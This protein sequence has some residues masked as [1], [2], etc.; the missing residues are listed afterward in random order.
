MRALAAVVIALVFGIFLATPAVAAMPAQTA[1]ASTKA[2]RKA[3]TQFQHDLVS[4]LALRSEAK[5]LLGA[6]LLAR[7]LQDLPKVIDFHHLI[8]R[9][10]KASD[11]GP[12]VTW[13]Q[14]VDCDAKTQA[15]PNADALK[16]LQQQAPDNAAVWLLALGQDQHNDNQDA[17]KADLKQAADADKYDDYIGNSLQ[18]LALAVATLPPLPDTMNPEGTLA[19]SPSGVQAML[20]F[21]IGSTQPLPGFQAAAALCAKNKDDDSMSDQCLKLGK[22][23]EWGSSALARS[24]GLHLRET[25]SKDPNEQADAKSARRDLIWQ[26]QNFTHLTAQAQTDPAVANRLLKLA[27]SGGTQMSMM[28]T[29]LRASN[30]PIE[31]PA[32]WQPHKSQ[33]PSDPV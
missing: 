25:L 26:V 14:L 10:A 2:Q 15:C 21:G 17:V 9:A 20:V 6:A 1:S 12:A 18:A 32:D 3:L 33:E 27:R 29:A 8:T 13:A 5:P 19:S 11:A 30:I 16:K 28:L 7:P 22:T 23:L 31:A 4:V 24:L